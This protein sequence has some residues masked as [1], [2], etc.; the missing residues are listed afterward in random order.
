MASTQTVCEPG[1]QLISEHL[2]TFL[3]VASEILAQS[4]KGEPHEA[5]IVSALSY[6]EKCSLIPL[7]IAC[8][9]R[10]EGYYFS[11]V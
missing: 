4:Q 5:A 11:S 3:Y 8:H 6:V 2:S 9:P 10:D 1:S 7:R